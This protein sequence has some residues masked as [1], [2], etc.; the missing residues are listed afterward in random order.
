LRKWIKNAQKHLE[1]GEEIDLDDDLDAELDALGD[2][3]E[4]LED[5]DLDDLD[6]DLAELYDED[7]EED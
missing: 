3:D 5:E 6:L 4:E 2:D 7:D 1:E